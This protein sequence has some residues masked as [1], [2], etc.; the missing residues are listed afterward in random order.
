AGEA[1][2]DFIASAGQFFYAPITMNVLPNAQIYSL[3]FNVT[4]ATNPG[5]V[6]LVEPGAV[7]FSS[8]LMQQVAPEFSD[9]L[10]PASQQW[11][12]TI[13]P[14]AVIGF[15]TN[16]FGFTNVPVFGSLLFTNS[17]SSTNLLGVGWLERWGFD[18]LYNTKIQDLISYSIAHD[19]LFVKGEGRV[20]LGAYGFKVPLGATPGE[21]YR[22][23]I[24]RPSATSDGVGA[25]GSSI[26]IDTPTNGTL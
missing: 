20:V 23:Q 13:P 5:T 16:S 9:H 22:I 12:A 19:T 17:N 10:P 2:S 4:V 25:P 3:Q 14:A 11:Y 7:A 26:F 6:H 21:N 18:W 24:A 15:T 8:T 1:S